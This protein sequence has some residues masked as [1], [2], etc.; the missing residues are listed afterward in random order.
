LTA[1]GGV[2][3]ERPS[4]SKRLYVAKPELGTKRV[5]PSCATKY[6][7]LQRN[8]ITCP[9]C[10]TIFE[11]AVRER[12]PERAK[13]EPKPKPVPVDEVEVERDEDV[14]SL[15]EVEEDADADVGPDLDEDEEAVIPVAD[16]DV[17]VDEDIETVED[18]F[19]ADEE[20]E[21]DDVAGL[22]DV[23]G[24]DEDEV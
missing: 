4:F 23:E 24:E 11:V 9:N 3:T 13:P 18:P 19:L 8:P 17:E 5:C 21:G 15:E 22:L 14:V 16:V 20:E 6:Y 2:S 7:D 12:A 1:A 10:G